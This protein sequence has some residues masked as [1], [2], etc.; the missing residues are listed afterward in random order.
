M[1]CFG[2]IDKETE[3]NTTRPL[4]PI[5]KKKKKTKRQRR[6]KLKN[7]MR[8]KNIKKLRTT[9]K[10]GKINSQSVEHK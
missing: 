7:M 1:L 6:K 2:K 8:G 4:K 5:R 9:M 10:E 3:R